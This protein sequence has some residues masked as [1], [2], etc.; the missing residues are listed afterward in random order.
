MDRLT[1]VYLQLTYDEYK[2]FERQMLDF[3]AQET[4]HT[5]ANEGF[6]HKAFRVRIGSLL[7]E[8][9]GP[10]VKRPLE[11]AVTDHL[12]GE[13]V[14]ERITGHIPHRLRRV[15]T[16]GRPD[17][18]D[19]MAMSPCPDWSAE[20]A[21]EPHLWSLGDEGARLACPGWRP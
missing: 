11:D 20:R 13:T 2:E 7:L 19:S 18:M 14:R 17:P 6:Y 16:G 8:V 1:N 4:T 15:V 21:H 12:D 5:T 9:Q 3:R 10:L